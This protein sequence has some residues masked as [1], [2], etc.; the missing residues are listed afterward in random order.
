MSPKIAE[1]TVLTKELLDESPN[2]FPNSPLLAAPVMASKTP[3][4][5][6]LFAK[7]PT[8]AGKRPLI[9]LEIPDSLS[10]K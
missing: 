10:P 8:T 2:R 3:G 5:S 6:A 9:A 7:P 1:S 4:L